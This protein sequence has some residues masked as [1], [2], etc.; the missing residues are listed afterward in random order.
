LPGLSEAA[1]DLAEGLGGPVRRGDPDSA[2]S[3]ENGRAMLVAFR[4]LAPAAFFGV[5]PLGLLLLAALAAVHGGNL[6]VDFRRELYP[7]TQLV[8]HGQNPFPSSASDLSGGA[9]L[10]FPIGAALLVSPLLLFSVAQA[11]IVFCVVLVLALAGTLW[12]LGVR[13]WRVYGVVGLWA[14]TLS[15][16]QTE[17]LTILLGLLVALAWRFRGH[18]FAPGL[19]IGGAIALKFFLWPLLIWFVAVRRWRSAAVAAMT[20]IAVTL[21][22]LPFESLRS[23]AELMNK[24]TKTFAGGSYSIEGFLL[25]SHLAA[26]QTAQLVALGFG[27]IVIA[28]AYRRRSLPLFV[29]ASLILS[30]IVWL[31]YL[32]LLV[33]PLALARP[34]LS[35]LWGLPLIFWLCPGNG[36]YVHAWHVALAMAVIASIA[37]LAE[38]RSRPP[39]WLRARALLPAAGVQPSS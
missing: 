13:D 16:L 5:L 23:Y 18:P 28:I 35:P 9:N 34:R 22:V 12:L 2:S 37:V 3:R 36:A 29:V 6:G 1:G 11:A 32:L 38:V 21:L 30:P 31:H 7:E 15:A 8:V 26:L 19:A 25:M 4:K 10:V 33:I 17:N 27:V 20:A 24:M 14:P 39:G